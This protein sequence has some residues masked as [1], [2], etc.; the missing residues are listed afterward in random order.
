MTV[1]AIEELCRWRFKKKQAAEKQREMH[2]LTHE[3]KEKWIVHYI[4]RETAEARKR[5]EDAQAAVQQEQDDTM[6]AEN[7]G[8]T[9]KELKYTV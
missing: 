8:L 7:A 6:T 4:E 9:N 2:Y 5:F 1:R 3:V